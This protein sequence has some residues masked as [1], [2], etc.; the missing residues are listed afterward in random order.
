MK[1]VEILHSRHF[2]PRIIKPYFS[3]DELSSPI[4][5]FLF[6][7]PILPCKQCIFYRFKVYKFNLGLC[8]KIQVK[9]KQ[10][11]WSKVIPYDVYQQQVP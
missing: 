6:P 3:Q 5:S 10:W 9:E 11:T 4:R 2:R 7:I 8:L 1:I